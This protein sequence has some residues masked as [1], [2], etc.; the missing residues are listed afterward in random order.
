M[1]II[2]ISFLKNH[3]IYTKLLFHCS[4]RIATEYREKLLKQWKQF[5]EG[6]QIRM[7]KIK[8]TK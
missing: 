3:V 5:K 6:K 8:K 2:L 7:I 1:I 4:L